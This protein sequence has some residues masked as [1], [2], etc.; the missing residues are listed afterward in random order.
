MSW[1]GSLPPT[2]TNFSSSTNIFRGPYCDHIFSTRGTN[3]EDLKWSQ[4]VRNSTKRLSDDVW[5]EKWQKKTVTAHSQR[6]QHNWIELNVWLIKEKPNIK[7]PAKATNRAK[8]QPEMTLLVSPGMPCMLVTLLLSKYSSQEAVRLAESQKSRHSLVVTVTLSITSVLRQLSKLWFCR[9]RFPNM[10]TLCV[11][12]EWDIFK[13]L[14]EMY[15]YHFIT[16]GLYVVFLFVCFRCSGVLTGNLA[17]QRWSWWLQHRWRGWREWHRPGRLM[18][19][20]WHIS[21]QQRRPRPWVPGSTCH[22]HAC[23]LAGQ[24]LHLPFYLPQRWL[25]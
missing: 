2:D 22:K 5:N 25:L 1:A 9:V 11:E 17:A 20:C 19:A 21:P 18:P 10:Q 24:V 15:R 7:S 8:F 3:T 4:T 12:K 16:L 23:Y 13:S 6:L 14:L